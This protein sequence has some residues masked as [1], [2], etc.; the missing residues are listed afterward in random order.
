MEIGVHDDTL[1]VDF[2]DSKASGGQGGGG[3]GT[4]RMRRARLTST[5]VVHPGKLSLQGASL[6][7]VWQVLAERG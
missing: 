6:C 5:K 2:R 1:C 7:L 3:K 4:M